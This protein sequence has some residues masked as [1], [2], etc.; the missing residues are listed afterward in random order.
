[1]FLNQE[2]Q[3]KVMRQK[4]LDAAQIIGVIVAVVAGAL[5]LYLLWSRGA[6]P[7]D[8]G[9]TQAECT[10]FFIRGCQNPDVWP[11]DPIKNV[12]CKSFAQN[13][14]GLDGPNCLGGVSGGVNPCI[15]FC[16]SVVS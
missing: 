5:I 6:I 15:A 8:F 3:N 4:G 10:A 12:V 11:V 1:M 16:Q 9:V 13:I 2:K 14:G 7:F